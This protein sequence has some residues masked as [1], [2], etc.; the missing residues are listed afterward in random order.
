METILV[1]K[2]GEDDGEFF[3]VTGLGPMSLFGTCIVYSIDSCTS[4]HSSIHLFIVILIFSL[5]SIQ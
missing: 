1:V 3:H 4:M 2:A 5:F